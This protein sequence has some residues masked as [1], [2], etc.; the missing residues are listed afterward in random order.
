MLTINE[1]IEYYQVGFISLTGAKVAIYSDYFQTRPLG[2]F[3]NDDRDEGIWLF[4]P[5]RQRD[6]YHQASGSRMSFTESAT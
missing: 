5:K 6:V 2:Y 1:W 3:A 4:Y